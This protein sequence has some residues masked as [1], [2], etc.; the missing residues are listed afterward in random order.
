M[1]DRLE[2]LD[3]VVF[4]ETEPEWTH[5]EGWYYGARFATLR[6]DDRVVATVA[7]DDMEFA[8]EWWQGDLLRLR[9]SSVMAHTWH[10]ESAGG[11]EVLRVAFN[12]ERI[13]FCELQLRPH[14]RVEWSMTWG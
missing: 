11:R 1:T 14:V 8:V 13:K 9:F 7:P 4:F 3:Y 12:D 5:A 10:I 6:G 2:L